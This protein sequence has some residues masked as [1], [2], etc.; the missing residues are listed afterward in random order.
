MNMLFTFLWGGLDTWVKVSDS[1]V[2][3]KVDFSE[4]S[5]FMSKIH[6]NAIWHPSAGK[7]INKKD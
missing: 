7:A 4:N 6:C 5:L 1:L 2:S 3:E